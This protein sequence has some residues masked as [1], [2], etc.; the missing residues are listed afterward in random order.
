MT[1]GVSAAETGKEPEPVAQAR[2]TPDV[3]RLSVVE[4]LRLERADR[5]RG[6]LALESTADAP[7]EER[8]RTRLER[9]RVDTGE[10]WN[11]RAPRRQC[12]EW[13]E[14]DVAQI[15]EV[16]LIERHNGLL[17]VGNTQFSEISR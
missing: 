13:H 16:L 4:P 9:D 17:V 5:H 15:G 7:R 1:D 11:I 10:I 14:P 2:R 12:T 6:V 8:S 3:D